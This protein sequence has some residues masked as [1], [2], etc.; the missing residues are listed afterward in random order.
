[1]YEAFWQL[2]RPPFVVAPDVRFL[3]RARSHHESFATLAA[4]VAR[5]AGVMVL[6][7][8]V[9]TGKTLVCRALG[10]ELPPRVRPVFLPNPYLAGAEL[11]G[12]ILDALGVAHAAG[13]IGER[14]A[15]LGRHLAAA[16]DSG[17]VLIV[18]DEAQILTVEALEQL[19]ILSALDGQG[20]PLVQVLLVGQP[21]LDD[22]LRR[23]ELH[24]LDQRVAVR[25]YLRRLSARDTARYVEHRLRVAG[26]VGELPFT[27]S[28]LDELHRRTRG[29]PRLV[30][31]VADRALIVACG[32]RSHVVTPIMVQAAARDVEGERRPGSR[33]FALRQAVPA[34]AAA[35]GVVLLAGAALVGYRVGP[36]IAGWWSASTR[37]APVTASAAALSVVAPPQIASAD[38]EAPAIAVAAIAVPTLA[39]RPSGT[40]PTAPATVSEPPTIS[41]RPN[42]VPRAE[43]GAG[44]TASARASRDSNALPGGAVDARAEATGSPTSATA[45]AAAAPIRPARPDGPAS[46]HRQILRRALAA[47]GVDDPSAGAGAGDIEAAARRHGLAA[48]RLTGLRLGDL[49]AVGLPAIVEMREAGARHPY[50][51]LAIDG[52][53]AT[54]VA[55][56]GEE[57]RVTLPLIESGWTRSALFLWRNADGLPTDAS[58]PWTPTVVAAMAARLR[59]L[60]FLRADAAPVDDPAV[61]EAVRGFQTSV[62]LPA[63]GLTG[64][65]TILALVRASGGH[66]P[67]GGRAAAR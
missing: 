45:V 53:A 29:I 38:Q 47:W 6:I 35:A 48:L 1:M 14:M 22:T 40:A 66:P 43:V 21:E 49:R 24:Q 18:V 36:D 10:A 57:A 55:P 58:Q 44:T 33:L 3:L 46:A 65:L 23:R 4:G 42:E 12:A 60:G 50:L 34:G 32:A 59:A 31:L 62:G 2:D 7:G 25:A 41:S 13:S 15:V 56:A 9:G 63:D 11:I 17:G 67:S 16:A 37:T 26:L 28:S 51:V 61:R 54:L 5:G 64:P 8:E 39:S 30:N 19:R 27:R 52:D 20:R